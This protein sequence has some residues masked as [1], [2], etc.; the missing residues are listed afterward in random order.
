MAWMV[1]CQSDEVKKGA[2]KR[3][4]LANGDPIGLTR[5]EDNR[6]VAFHNECPHA[7]GPL[8]AGKLHGDEIVC[9]WHFFRFNLATGK[10]EGTP[11]SIMHLK[12]YQIEEKDGQVLIEQ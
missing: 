6:V 3:Q 9:P 7:K 12:I 2:F 11:E 4:R 10:A 5:L 8:T 1:A